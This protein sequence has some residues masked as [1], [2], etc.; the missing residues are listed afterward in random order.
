[1]HNVSQQ[2]QA[3]SLLVP[4]KKSE[5]QNYRQEKVD[6][7]LSHAFP[8][9]RHVLQGRCKRRD[10][11]T[12]PDAI[13]AKYNM[14]WPFSAWSIIAQFQFIV[15]I[16]EAGIVEQRRLKQVLGIGTDLLFRYDV[17]IETAKPIADEQ[18]ERILGLIGA[19]NYDVHRLEQLPEGLQITDRSEYIDHIR[20]AA[21]GFQ[22]GLRH[23]VQSLMLRKIV[24]K[25]ALLFKHTISDA[26]YK[27]RTPLPVRI[28]ANN[29]LC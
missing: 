18:T 13:L 27:L 24:S 11:L 28:G 23:F 2:I 29:V 15:Q 4:L 17:A 25:H 21:N 8:G 7:I 9:E 1:M 12:K 19:L 10:Q 22:D 20:L 5:I 3:K 14:D 26:P 16:E 6:A